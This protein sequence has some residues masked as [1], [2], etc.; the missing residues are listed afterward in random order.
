M[1]EVLDH[2]DEPVPYHGSQDTEPPQLPFATSVGPDLGLPASSKPVNFFR[3]LFTTSV[4]QLIVD[5]TNR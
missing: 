3:V 2:H 1:A 5:E 4:I